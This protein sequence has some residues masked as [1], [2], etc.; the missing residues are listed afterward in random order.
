MGTS[1]WFE[2][3]P[4]GGLL[5][6]DLWS[7]RS[8]G[9][10]SRRRR[11]K[12]HQAEAIF[13]LAGVMVREPASTLEALAEAAVALCEAD[14]AGVSLRCVAADG[15]PSH[16]WVATA[17]LYAGAL[18]ATLPSAM[19]ACG[20]YLEQANPM[21]RNSV[22]VPFSLEPS[23][24][25]GYLAQS[26]MTDGL[27]V[28]WAEEDLQGILWVTAHARGDAFD[29]QDVRQM[30]LLC[31][32][33]G[34]YLIAGKHGGQLQKRNRGYT[35]EDRVFSLSHEQLAALIGELLELRGAWP[36]PAGSA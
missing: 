8:F 4:Y 18:R 19:A 25:P 24:T 12:Q 16:E 3:E 1:A 20:L 15:T 2:T 21:H 26:V 28:P 30:E 33:A 17:G 22:P 6:H 5:L 10:R 7:C 31:S 32:F 11:N 36:G 23:G 34:V 13:R 14:S 27:L 35:A 9:A 29:L